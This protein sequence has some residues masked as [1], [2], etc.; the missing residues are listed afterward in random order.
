MFSISLLYWG[1]C[2][3]K[4]FLFTRKRDIHTK[5]DH[6]LLKLFEMQRIIIVIT[7]YTYI[8]LI[9][10]LMNLLIYFLLDRKDYEHKFI[11]K[12][13]KDISDKINRVPLYVSD[14]LVGLKSRI[15]KVNSLLDSESND[16]VCIIGIHGTGGICL[17]KLHM[18]YIVVL[19]LFI[20]YYFM[21]ICLSK[22]HK[23]CD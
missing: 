17:L 4:Q 7:N 5:L 23:Y 16:G 13:V 1:I 10:I 12:V 2:M 20:I 15:S 3:L 11:E 19:L 14:Y 22:L 6:C 8:E 21:N 9:L 18:Y